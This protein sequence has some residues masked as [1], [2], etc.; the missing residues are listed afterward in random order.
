MDP[1]ALS[2]QLIELI[3]RLWVR[4]TVVFGPV[5]VGRTQ[6]QLREHYLLELSRG[7][8]TANRVTAGQIGRHLIDRAELDDE[9][10]WATPL[11]RILAWHVGYPYERCPAALVGAILGTSRQ[12]GWRKAS[13]M[14]IS[15]DERGRR[16]VP[17]I[18]VRR[19]ARERMRTSPPL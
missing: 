13:E 1:S 11:G 10:F 2:V 4:S 6:E 19:L 15:R 8:E 18:E 16:Y 5:E 7:S 14:E 17:S 12:Y 3:D 9:A